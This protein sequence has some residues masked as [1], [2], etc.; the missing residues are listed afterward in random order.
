MT[1]TIE[2]EKQAVRT[3]AT[4]T[5]EMPEEAY[6]ASRDRLVEAI[7]AAD[8]VLKSLRTYTNGSDDW[9]ARYPEG[10]APLSVLRLDLSLGGA[11]GKRGGELVQSLDKNAIARLLDERVAHA[12][13]HL[14]HLRTRIT[15]TQSKV[16]VTGDLNAGKSTLV[17]ALLRRNM[18]PTDQQPCTM[19]FCEVLDARENG[20]KEAIHV[21][22]SEAYNPCDASTYTERT[23]DELE[24][25]FAELEEEGDAA[26]AIR[27]YVA[28][29]GAKSVL[30]GGAVDIAL[31]DAPGL[32]RDSVKTTAVFAREERIDVVVFVVSAENHFTLSAREFL[33]NAGNDKAYVFV[34]VNK[35]ANIRNKDKCRRLVLEQL[36]ELSPR[37][38]ANADELVHFADAEL[39]LSGASEEATCFR[40][41]ESALRDFV[42]NRRAASKL[43]PAQT[44]LMR[45][46]GD[47][48]SLAKLNEAIARTESEAARATL[49]EARPALAACEASGTEAAHIAEATEDAA[50][51]GVQD[52]TERALSSA[53]ETLSR[54]EPAHASVSLPAFPGL[55][56]VY[57]YAQDVRYTLAHSL[58]EAVYDTEDAAREATCKAVAEIDA[59]GDHLGEAPRRFVPGAM[60]PRART[61]P[62]NF[63]GLGIDGDIV[64]F[65]L[66]DVFDVAHHIEL[67]ASR[68][69]KKE[70][71]RSVTSMSLG[72]GALTLVGSR[73]LGF[74]S[75]VDVFFR[76]TDMLGSRVVRRW[77]G[78]VLLLAG[79]GIVA[80]LVVDLPNAIPR[81]VGRS[82]RRELASGHAMSDP[83][84][85]NALM[86]TSTDVFSS[87]HGA[88]VARETRKILRIAS[89]D[90]Q[91]RFRAAVASYRADVD[92]A[93]A[94]EK[95][96][97]LALA[98]FYE[99]AEKSASLSTRVEQALSA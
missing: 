45:L 19:A 16:L 47:V 52:T 30:H 12:L 71:E 9:V 21:L 88:R 15:D 33:E 93:E 66:T 43:L 39:A 50:I 14:G 57:E 74:R 87:M 94:Q 32:N 98:W 25:L 53:L 63:A 38:F 86:R 26:P 54:G 96:A 22:K 5:P 64:G 40:E 31:I 46:L 92:R 69:S 4:T 56:N 68:V 90:L 73:S 81:N 80:W 3:E 27:I 17:N 42:L 62:L 1:A 60:F 29:A 24:A 34:V 6:T 8:D 95:C 20:G 89:W 36:R 7:G 41:L 65:R 91:E 59:L 85:G 84:N 61:G 51:A 83:G 37:T 76:V 44:Y 48:V 72:L 18:V 11:A 67:V 35:F 49:A 75:G 28:D 55:L 10:Q 23:I 2:L 82:M 13:A 77:A 79:A 78:P 70:D 97:M 58:R 99:A